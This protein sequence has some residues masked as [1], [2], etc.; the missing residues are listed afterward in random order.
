MTDEKKPAQVIAKA[1]EDG[2][3]P[4]LKKL[5]HQEMYDLVAKFIQKA[6]PIKG[7][8][9]TIVKGLNN[10][11]SS[12]K[13]PFVLL[14]ITDVNQLSTTE[15]YYTNKHKILWARSEVTISIIFFG[16][17]K[18]SAIEMAQSFNIRFNDAWASEQFAQ[19]S[20]VFFPLYSDKLKTEPVFMDSEEQ[21]EDKCSVDAYFELHPEFGVC[22]DSAKEIVMDIENT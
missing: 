19:Y 11:V 17:E 21:F 3:F 14:Q 4:D 1:S 8:E 12:P 10:R 2:E 5:N 16:N 7:A 18:I 13:T 22:S 15:T 9:L 20:K 6:V